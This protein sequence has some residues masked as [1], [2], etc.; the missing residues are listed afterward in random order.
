MSDSERDEFEN[1]Q[2]ED[3]ES[4]ESESVEETEEEEEEQEAGSDD[5][6]ATGDID[7]FED[8]NSDEE[9]EEET[10]QIIYSR[11]Q[12]YENG[13]D[14]IKRMGY[15]NKVFAEYPKDGDLTKDQLYELCLKRYHHAKFGQTY[16][17]Q[18][19]QWFEYLDSLVKPPT[20]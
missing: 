1:D 8:D 10:P 19:Q 17:E 18:D 12:S 6:E 16:T 2:S 4:S 3:V 5:E 20:K 9:F 7:V 14:Y 11:R 13:I 15:T